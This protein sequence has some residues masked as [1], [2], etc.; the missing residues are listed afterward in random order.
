[1]AKDESVLDILEHANSPYTYRELVLMLKDIK[2]QS[3]VCKEIKHLLKM[4]QL[5]R[6]SIKIPK[7]R[8]VVFYKL[9]RK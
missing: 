6:V 9:N 8:S 1:M 2:N 4:E 5:I 3:S 7:C